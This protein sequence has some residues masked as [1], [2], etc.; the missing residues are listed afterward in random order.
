MAWTLILTYFQ[1]HDRA[2]KRADHV[3][4]VGVPEAV[5]FSGWVY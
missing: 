1:R 4:G 2:Q 5:A 3:V